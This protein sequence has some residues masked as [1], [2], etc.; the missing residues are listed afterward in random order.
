LIWRTAVHFAMEQKWDTLRDPWCKIDISLASPPDSPLSVT[1]WEEPTW[2]DFEFITLSSL[3]EPWTSIVTPAAVVGKTSDAPA[4]FRRIKSWIT[5][6]E[7]NH[8]DCKTPCVVQLPT[9]VIDVN[10]TRKGLRPFLLE[11]NGLLGRYAAL[12]YV[13]GTSLPLKVTKAT[14]ESFKSGIAWSSIPKTLQDAMTI[15]HRLGLRY[16]WIDALTIIQDDDQDWKFEVVKMPSVYGNAYITIAATISGDCHA[17]IFSPRKTAARHVRVWPLGPDQSPVDVETE[18]LRNGEIYARS[19]WNRDTSH[20]PLQT[21][22]WTLQEH[23][24]SRRV[25]QYASEEL[26]WHCRTSRAT[27]SAPTLR[28]TSPKSANDYSFNP[29]PFP[30]QNTVD[31]ATMT[32][33]LQ[34]WAAFIENYTKRQLTVESD[35]LPAISGIAKAFQSSGMGDT[36]RAGLWEADLLAG[37][38]WYSRSGIPRGAWAPTHVRPQRY[39]APSWSWASLDGELG[40]SL[41]ADEHEHLRA[42]RAQSCCCCVVSV[43]DVELVLRGLV[44]NGVL[45]KNRACLP[46]KLDNDTQRGYKSGSGELVIGDHTDTSVLT[47]IIDT[48]PMH[49]GIEGPRGLVKTPLDVVCLLLGTQ[50]PTKHTHWS[51]VLVLAP[52][53]GRMG[54]YERVG[55][56]TMLDAKCFRGAEEMEVTII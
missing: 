29:T 30:P 22:G 21:R 32:H 51:T 47:D 11:S 16:I 25:I 37:L 35:K 36:Y 40:W 45:N 39:R 50:E 56:S 24:L 2:M 1:C 46:T 55:V 15:T 44:V 33:L 12:S 38:T 49:P 19:G 9:R 7:T 42:P 14:L 5:E 8:P 23:I 6:C 52:V 31:A 53:G 3:P 34:L 43:S 41:K 10:P 17:G 48:S 13:W 20:Y 28:P 4:C 54:V 27:E 26:I 18:S